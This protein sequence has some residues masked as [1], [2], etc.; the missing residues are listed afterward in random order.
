MF[1]FKA[2]SNRSDDEI[3][4]ESSR[5]VDNQSQTSKNLDGT[6]TPFLIF[7]VFTSVVGASF[8]YGWN[9]GV[10]NTPENVIKDFYREVYE[11]RYK[12]EMSNDTET[13]LWSVTNGLMP[14]GGIFGGLSSGFF[15]DQLGRY[16]QI[17]EFL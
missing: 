7:C 6:F 8:Q 1:I 4:N 2:S 14:L 16:L 5:L 13:L 12:V 10:F 11:E 17:F 9:L 3:I 15:A